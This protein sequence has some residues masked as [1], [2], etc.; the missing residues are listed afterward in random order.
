M[1]YLGIF[2]VSL[3]LISLDNFDFSTNFTA[4]TATIN[5]I[6]PGMGKVGPY[7]NFS[8]FSDFSKLIFCF[9]MI[10][11]RLEILPILVLIN[12][13]TWSKPFKYFKKVK[14]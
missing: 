5:N 7:G 1:G 8:E 4:V 2:A 12:P 3:L 10:A 13:K 6:G 11:G 14:Q 9:N